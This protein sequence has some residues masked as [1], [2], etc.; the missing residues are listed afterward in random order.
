MSHTKKIGHFRD[1]LP[2]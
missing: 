1:V 2:N